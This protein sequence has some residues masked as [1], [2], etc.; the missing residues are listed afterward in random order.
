MDA[1]INKMAVQAELDLLRATTEDQ[2]LQAEKDKLLAQTTKLLEN[3]KLTADE[4]KLIWEK[5][6]A[7]IDA[8][9][10]GSI[11]KRLANI[12]NYTD[13]FMNSL[14]AVSQFYQQSLSNELALLQ[15]STRMK[16]EIEQRGHNQ[17]IKNIQNA[18]TQELALLNSKKQRNKMSEEQ[19]N[20]E[21]LIINNKK[22][23]N[24]LKEMQRYENQKHGIQEAQIQRE[25]TIK[26]R[27]AVLQ[28]IAA[29]TEAGIDLAVL[30]FKAAAAGWINPLA[31]LKF[32]GATLKFGLLASMPIPEYA[33]GG[34]TVRAVGQQT[35]K[36]YNTTYVGS[37]A[38]G[39][40]AGSPQLG[41][42]GEQG[43]ELIIPNWLYTHPRMVDTMSALQGMIS[44][45]Q[46]ADGGVTAP[47]TM[48]Q[49]S[50]TDDRLSVLI[51][52]NMNLMQI[53]AERMNMPM[54]ANI[55]YDQLEDVLERMNGIK[56]KA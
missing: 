5:Y 11:D 40:V 46:F 3:D 21:M 6:A 37:V 51:S 44:A 8:L 47:V 38:R 2:R 9:E 20:Q 15:Q 49:S 42:I 23:D 54:V 56:S 18:H 32:F 13:V 39:G 25:R 48:P 4:R 31:N 10:M 41:I 26:R 14:Q 16:N 43:P 7:E 1:E 12:K 30:G 45:R 33:L 22:N 34:P 35:G 24:E 29:V 17:N 52:Q 27:M 36:T 50:N 19:Y 28:K 55:T 53:I